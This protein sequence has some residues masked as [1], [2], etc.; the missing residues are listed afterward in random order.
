MKLCT[1][2]TQRIQQ[3]TVFLDFQTFYSIYKTKRMIQNTPLIKI[4]YFNI[5]G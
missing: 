1:R 4:F 5:D 3:Q 2:S